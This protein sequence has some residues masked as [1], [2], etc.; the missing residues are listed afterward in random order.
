MDLHYIKL[1]RE[2]DNFALFT[3]PALFDHPVDSARI[4]RGSAKLGTYANKE[5]ADAPHICVILDKAWG[6]MNRISTITFALWYAHH[7]GAGVNVEW[8]SNASCKNAFSELWTFDHQK[9]QES[10]N[11]KYLRVMTTYDEAGRKEMY[12]IK[13]ATNCIWAINAFI[14]ADLGIEYVQNIW[15]KEFASRQSVIEALMQLSSQ[16]PLPLLF[17]LFQIKEPYVLEAKRYLEARSHS[18]SDPYSC[19][20]PGCGSIDRKRHV[21]YQVRLNDWEER[22]AQTLNC[23]AADYRSHVLQSLEHY[24][25]YAE[26]RVHVVTDSTSFC[27]QAWNRLK[28]S[29]DPN[30]GI[31][32]HFG[33]NW[34]KL[35]E[36]HGKMGVCP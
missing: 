17:S 24:L 21:V 6:V 26:C 34:D 4:D 13:T 28:D 15:E 9:L 35:Q 27:E 29:A 3:V 20:K 7:V 18:C 25:D 30:G 32:F 2:R 36:T 23:T 10:T 11:V 8:C 22:I 1:I 31:I 12:H 5:H 14:K 33:P 16:V 19:V